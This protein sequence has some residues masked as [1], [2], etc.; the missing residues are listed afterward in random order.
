MNT[1]KIHFFAARMKTLQPPQ[2][3]QSMKNIRSLLHLLGVACAA[4]LLLAAAPAAR[5]ATPTPPGKL[6][7]QGFLTDVNGLPLGNGGPV[8]ST[9]VFRIY[10]NATGTAAS[11]LVWSES[12]VVTIDKGHFSVLLGEGSL[13]TGEENKNTNNLSGVFTGV[14]ASD[15]FMG[16]TVGTTNIAPRLQFLPAP[17]ALLAKSANVVVDGAGNSV[18]TTGTSTIGINKGAAV[19]ASAL[20]VNGTVTATGL[21]VN[22][23]ASATTF[24]GAHSGNA[25][26]LTSI[27]AGQL[28]G[29]VPN[30]QLSGTYGSA[31]TL[32]NAGNSLS[33]NGSGLTSLN[34]NNITAGTIADSKLATITTGGKVAN[35][36]TTA[37]SGNSG[38]AIVMRDGSGD[39]TANAIG[40]GGVAATKAPLQISSFYNISLGVTRYYNYGGN[41]QDVAGT[42]SLSIYADVDIA[43]R[44]YLAFSDERIK[45]IEGRSDASQDLNTLLGIEITD[46]RYKDVVGKGNDPHKKVIA[47]QVEK[48]FAQAVSKHT[49]TVPDI[50][51]KAPIKDGWV[52]LAT[53]LKKGE[54][55]KL[56]S[57]RGEGV[58]EVLEATKTRFRTSLKPEGDKV[59]VFGREVNDFRNVDY[60]A[61]AMLNVSATQE[62]AKQVQALHKSASR[63]AELE[64]K[65]SQMEG[66]EREVA[67]LK[68]LVAQLADLRKGERTVAGAAVSEIKAQASR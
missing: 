30:A 57:E 7:Y 46:Y 21:Q 24:S 50:Y 28:T 47:Q 6:T 58:Y 31:L 1:L 35:S 26:G 18:L 49:D 32:N 29:T 61:I 34:G 8:N 59:F 41:A 25:S 9:V 52:E 27:P 42:R 53:D 64:Q 68:K 40:L 20:D 48:V 56:I 62:L 17:Y 45:R 67:Q 23:T 44:Q 55:V 38:N 5:A 60:E 13:V 4:I 65:V 16:I 15:R 66:L 19:P 37:T 63:V 51:Q 14:D 33:G 39:F 43:S 2:P 54:R 12:Q 3:N 11:D 10:R 36:A 22:G